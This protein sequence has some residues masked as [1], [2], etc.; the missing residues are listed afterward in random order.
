MKKER[1]P[2]IHPTA[3]IEADEF[4]IGDWSVIGANVRIRGKRVVIGRAAWI[5][6]N[7]TIGGGRAELGTLFAGDFLHMGEH[8]FINIARDVVIGHEVGLGRFTN[9]YTH[10]GYL[11]T[12]DGFPHSVG[13]ITIGDN[14]W[15]P[16]ATV[17]PNVRIGNRVV[18]AAESLVN[19][20]LPPCCLAG[21][22]PARVIKAGAYPLGQKPSEEEKELFFSKIVLSAYNDY[23]VTEKI[24]VVGED[25]NALL[26]GEDLDTGT[27]FFPESRSMHGPATQ[28]TERV[29]DLL[30][31]E[32]IR[33]RY[34]VG[35][36]GRYKEWENE[37]EWEDEF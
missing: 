17:L 35:E 14:V 7:A 16:K 3:K 5:G 33:F 2:K 37:E 20:D 6:D 24:K 23:G 36:D 10:G 8:S 9:L 29:K 21:G 30:R 31:R 1:E 34:Y 27:F 25:G 32:G 18:V 12:W 15:L 4:H 13:E 22:I 19:K 28:A 11:S 26:V